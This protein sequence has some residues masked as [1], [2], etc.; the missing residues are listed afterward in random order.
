M[1]SA[2]G[3]APDSAPEWAER[4][5]TH[6]A[7]AKSV[8]IVK[9]DKVLARA[10]CSRGGVFSLEPP[11][12]QLAVEF[13]DANLF[14]SSSIRIARVKPGT[15]VIGAVRKAKDRCHADKRYQVALQTDDTLF[16]YSARCSQMRTPFFYDI[17]DLV[18]AIEAEGGKLKNLA[19]VNE[20]GAF[21]HR[22]VTIETIRKDASKPRKLY[23][24]RFPAS[25]EAHKQ[26]AASA[27][28]T[29]P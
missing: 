8:E 17:A 10:L 23:K 14:Q 5:A 24:Y 15:D 9:A 25:R 27:K 2:T 29:S 7:H 20:C 4:L 12:A 26:S 3:A 22:F 1:S 19:I 11:F 18:A 28:R 6:Y 13:D 16:M 21:D